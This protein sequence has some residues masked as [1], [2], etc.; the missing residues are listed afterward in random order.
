MC[1]LESIYFLECVVM[2]F[3]RLVWWVLR[4]LYLTFL[5]AIVSSCY[6]KEKCFL[7][8]R[9]SSVACLGFLWL[10]HVP[11]KHVDA[12]CGRLSWL[13][14]NLGCWIEV[15]GKQYLNAL[16]TDGKQC[17][18]YIYKYLIFAVSFQTLHLRF[19][20]INT[21]KRNLREQVY[22]CPLKMTFTQ[23]KEMLTCGV[24]LPQCLVYA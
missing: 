1:S 16:F 23:C 4:S 22:F 6:W 12:S 11:F 3:L 5:I 21:G 19:C 24:N 18:L 8:H 17:K 9:C 14:S 2:G 15:G 10:K 7:M 20:C 13:R